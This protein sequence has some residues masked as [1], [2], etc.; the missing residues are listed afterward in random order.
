MLIFLCVRLNSLCINSYFIKL[1]LLDRKTVKELVATVLLNK[2][3]TSMVNG[4]VTAGET[5]QQNIT[6]LPMYKIFIEVNQISLAPS[7]KVSKG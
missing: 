3:L 6:F 4:L 7:M 5:L 2:E 1:E